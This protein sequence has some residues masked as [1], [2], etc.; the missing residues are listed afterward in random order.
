MAR[1]GMSIAEIRSEIGQIH[2]YRTIERGV[3]EIRKQQA[4]EE[5]REQALKEGLRDHWSATIEVLDEVPIDRFDWT[6]VR[7]HPAFDL[8]SRTYLGEGWSAK[9][10]SGSWKIEF[11]FEEKTQTNLLR[12]HLPKDQFWKSLDALRPALDRAITAR[13]NM[14]LFL[15]DALD[16]IGPIGENGALEVEASGLH[17]IE[18]QLLANVLNDEYQPEP[19]LKVDPRGVWIEDYLLIPNGDRS[20]LDRVRNT[21]AS[22]RGTEEWKTLLSANSEVNKALED[23]KK[24]R[25]VLSLV[26]MLPGECSLCERYSV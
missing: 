12:E 7:Q 24:E 11:G 6:K 4:R 1:S 15:R 25:D 22:L 14:L 17:R 23:L 26:T 8:D 18:Q 5:A 10:Q 9:R 21:I 20:L 2:D 13:M 16:R 19:D 3:A